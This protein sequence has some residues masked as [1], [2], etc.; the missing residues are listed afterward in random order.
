MLPTHATR[1]KNVRILDPSDCQ[2]DA[3]VEAA[4]E[5]HLEVVKLLVEVS[6]NN[7]EVSSNNYAAL[8]ALLKRGI[9]IYSRS[10]HS[11]VI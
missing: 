11:A 2:D 8:H 4:A 10:F 5:G 7:Y 1:R 9:V 6:S 3:L